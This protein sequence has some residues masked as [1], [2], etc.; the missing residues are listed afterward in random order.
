MGTW[1]ARGRR[2]GK[3][4]PSEPSCSSLSRAEPAWLCW[5]RSVSCVARLHL[6]PWSE[7]ETGK[8]EL[9]EAEG[10]NRIVGDGTWGCSHLFSLPPNRKV[11]RA[12]QLMDPA[13][14]KWKKGQLIMWK[15][16]G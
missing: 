2:G 13:E 8:G 9:K 7:K 1:V 16:G 15:K 12:T 3:L 6:H 11:Q 14:A 10:E 4:P 5:W